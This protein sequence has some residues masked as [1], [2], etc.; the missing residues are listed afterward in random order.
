MKLI[1]RSKANKAIITTSNFKIETKVQ[2][3][4]L[5]YKKIILQNGTKAFKQINDELG[6]MTPKTLKVSIKDIKK[7]ENT[8]TDNIKIAILQAANNI[9][10]VC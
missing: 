3:S 6:L 7:S 10:T 4:I 5:R 9:K 8:L 1:N 2:N